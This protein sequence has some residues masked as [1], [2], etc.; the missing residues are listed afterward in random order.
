MATPPEPVDAC[1]FPGLTAATP[2]LLKNRAIMVLGMHR[3]GTSAFSGVLSLMG[4][5]LGSRLLPAT[6]A[7]ASGYW[8]H[9]EVVAV[10]DSLLM[11]LGSKWDDPRGLP[12][13]WQTSDAAAG[14]RTKLRQIIE[15]DFGASP[16]WALKDPRLCKLLPLWIPLL[17]EIGCEP[18]WVLLARHPSESIRSLETREGF[19]R[20]KSELLWLRH[21]LDAERE[22]RDRN[23]VV[24]TFDQLLGDWAATLE[25]V[26]RAAG[27]PW[28][29]PPE[30]TNA[31]VAEFLDPGQRHHHALETG[32]LSQWTRDAY[33]GILAGAGGDEAK[34]R[35]LIERTQTTFATAEALYWPYLGD[36]LAAADAKYAALFAACSAVKEKYRLFEGKARGKIRRAKG[37][38]RANAAV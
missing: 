38:K 10:H 30:H 28:P 20:E 1:V 19:L 11:A 14:H 18:V 4:V 26:R 16:L 13:G 15:R 8:E 37:R 27:I 21:T 31:R 29:V 22:T 5:D 23:R 17:D 33:E 24:I 2:M 12:A 25:R 9:E 34:F 35:S 6:P 7:N 32:E 3:S 36:Q